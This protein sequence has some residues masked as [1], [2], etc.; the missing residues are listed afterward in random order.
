MNSLVFL[1]SLYVI[2]CYVDNIFNIIF[3]NNSKLNLFHS[4]KSR[5]K[6]P[7]KKIPQCFQ[8]AFSYADSFLI[9]TVITVIHSLNRR[10][11]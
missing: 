3:E 5:V 6:E 10:Q 1:T 4:Y 2:L 11:P 7:A 9:L 8:G